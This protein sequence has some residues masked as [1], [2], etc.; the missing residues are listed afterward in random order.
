MIFLPDESKKTII[1]SQI[2]KIR[3][4][5][6][7]SS[8]IEYCLR[9]LYANRPFYDTICANLAEDALPLKIYQTVQ[10]GPICRCGNSECDKFIFTECHFSLMKK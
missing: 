2:E 7:P 8:L 6:G 9:G 3:S 5:N 1:P 10:H 4:E